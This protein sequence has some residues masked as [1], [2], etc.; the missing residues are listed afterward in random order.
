MPAKAVEVVVP[1]SD[2]SASSVSSSSAPSVPNGYSSYLDIPLEKLSPGMQ[3]FVATKKQHPDCLL[4]FRMGDFY[5]TFYEDAK[6]VAKELDI[7]LTARGQGEK[8][9]PLAGVPYHALEPN[10]AKLVKNGHNVAIVE[11]LEDPKL[12]KGLVKRGVVRIVTPGMMIDQGLLDDKTNNYV[13][14]LTIHGDSLACAFCDI[15]TGE[16]FAVPATVEQLSTVVSRFNPAECIVPVSLGVNVD[17]I[18]LLKKQNVIVQKRLDETFAHGRAHK[19]LL[20]HF[21]LKS[22]EGF[23]LEGLTVAASGALLSYII[24]TQKTNLSYIN[25]ITVAHLGN[26]MILDGQTI[27]NLELFK[28]IRDGSTR[29]T[30]LSVVDQTKTSMGSRLLRKWIKEPLLDVQALHTRLNSVEWLVKQSI[31]RQELIALLG[32]VHDIERLIGR[33][34]YGT[35]NA[36]DLIALQQ[37]LAV[38]PRVIEIAGRILELYSATIGDVAGI[39][40]LI[41]SAIADE[42]PL[43]VREGNMIRR[44]H[45]AELDKLHEIKKNG[46]NIIRDLENSER[47]NTGIKTMHVK[48]NNVFGYFFEVSKSQVD[49]VPAHYIRKQTTANGERYITPELKEQEDLI[50]HAEEKILELEYILFIELLKKVTVKT[51]EIQTIAGMLAQI[52]VYCSFAFIAAGRRYVRPVLDESAVI[53]L[54]QSRHPVLEQLEQY[55]VPNDIVLNDG[56]LRI[57]TGPNMAGKS[58]LMRQTALC[59]LL[60]QIGSFVPAASARI[61][62]VDRIFTRVG[63][64]DDLATGQSTF[65]VEMTETAQILNNATSRSLIILDEIGRGTST[66]DGMS[67]AWSVAEYIVSKLKAKTL[68]ATHYHHLNGL[69][70]EF[71]SVTNYSVAVK[72]DGEEI[73]FLHKLV[74]GSADKSYGIHVAR[75]AGLPAEV[76]RRAREMQGK[77]EK[78]G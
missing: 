17:I 72:E 37:S 64:S 71:S 62:V 69:A 74:E 4:L 33:V 25:K 9:A 1:V 38:V 3:Q 46:T 13:M 26:T 48:F 27:R 28:N 32:D 2:V 16:F 23:G 12:A 52:D 21:K 31:A 51:V 77:L 18:D 65:M 49:K 7:V 75:L 8:R 30:L 68:F 70:E 44:A 41:G 6:I 59:V 56:E 53:E 36:R 34:T 66:F 29:G 40:S 67:I 45:H 35:A 39:V 54:K 55:Y 19:L 42:P 15:S 76:V 24:D 20:E 47:E 5:E 22:I 14:A 58:S 10:L 63:A 43:S 61:G 57:I 60:A 78:N 50:L 73:I 11:Q